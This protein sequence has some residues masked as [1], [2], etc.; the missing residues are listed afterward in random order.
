[1]AYVCNCRF[2][3]ALAGIARTSYL[4]L[5]D[6]GTG[7]GMEMDAMIVVVLGGTH[8]FGGEGSV[9]RTMIGVLVLMSLTAGMQ[10]AGVPPIGSI[11]SGG[12]FDF[13]A[14]C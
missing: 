9:W 3:S 4:H 12:G 11:P 13:C 6:P 8:F 14:A 1:M 2:C 7:Q 5:G 10:V